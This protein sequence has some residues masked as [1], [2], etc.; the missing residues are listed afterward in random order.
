MSIVVYSND[1]TVPVTDLSNID[2]DQIVNS[3]YTNPL[4]A[5]NIQRH[6]ANTDDQIDKHIPYRLYPR[7]FPILIIFCLC[8]LTSGF[9]WIEYVIIQNIIVRYYNE[10]LP[11]AEHTANDMVT[12]TSLLYM[13]TYIP[14]AFPAM[15]LLDRKG[16]KVTCSTGAFL[17]A[18]GALIKCASVKP[19]RWW[20]TFTGQFICAC[21]QSF[22]LG[23]PPFLA[24]T[25]FGADSVSTVTSL[26][27]FGNQVGIALGCVIPASLVPDVDDLDLIGR[28]LQI[29]FFSV[30]AIC[31]LVFISMIVVFRRLPPTPPS[32]AQAQ[33]LQTVE[34]NYGKTLKRLICNRWFLLLLL[35][36]G[37]STGSFYAVSTLLNPIYLSYF[38]KQTESASRY[39]GVIGMLLILGGIPGALLA[40]FILDRTKAYKIVTFGVYLLSFLATLLFTLTIQFHKFVA[41]FTMTLLGFFMT[42]YL[43]VGFEYGVE[44]T[45]PQNEAISGS[46]LNVASQIFGLTITKLQ[47]ILIFKYG[48]V[49]WS[50][51]MLCIVLAVGTIITGLIR[52]PLRR[53]QAQ[54]GPDVLIVN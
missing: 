10:S 32:R 23:I 16:L 14:L 54:K 27:V 51:L 28:R 17:N 46:L 36:Y 40:G 13:V 24:A 48:K 7:R 34:Q 4:S 22:T 33:S 1:T 31:T 41:F 50:N 38:D 2:S 25:W 19:T 6:Q 18:L 29:L 26:A 3:D 11:S 52:S 5:T 15:W 30:G 12:W 9:Q 21:A 43:P 49:F 20:V 44:I 8:S 35:S 45:Y 47:E 37:L 53:Q 39:A 42:G